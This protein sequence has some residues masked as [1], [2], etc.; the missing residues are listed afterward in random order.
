MK[1]TVEIKTNGEP[2]KVLVDGQEY[3][4]KPKPKFTEFSVHAESLSL[5]IKEIKFIQSY[6]RMQVLREEYDIPEGGRGYYVNKRNKIGPYHHLLKAG[7]EYA[8]SNGEVFAPTEELAKEIVQVR[9]GKWLPKKYDR[10]CAC[11]EKD[12]THGWVKGKTLIVAREDEEAD[13]H[14]HFPSVAQLLLYVEKHKP[15]LPTASELNAAWD[16]VKSYALSYATS[17]T[18][19]GKRIIQQ[20]WLDAVIKSKFVADRVREA[21]KKIGNACDWS[22]ND[23]PKYYVCREFMGAPK[24]STARYTESADEFFATEGG[25]KLY[26]SVMG[27]AI[28]H[29]LA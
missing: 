23:D 11:N 8:K 3:D 19:Y 29:L 26:L 27:D 15:K 22:N 13:G 4:K 21:E 25:A 10:Y 1:T 6:D 7:Y 14:L 5:G 16:T 18:Y 17:A 24:V 20:E 9:E 12:L 2:V 28:K